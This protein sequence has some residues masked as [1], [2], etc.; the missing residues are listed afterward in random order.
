LLRR[1]GISAALSGAGLAGAARVT[2][3]S[4]EARP[5]YVVVVRTNAALPER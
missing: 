1:D 3:R 4:R 5:P 2:V